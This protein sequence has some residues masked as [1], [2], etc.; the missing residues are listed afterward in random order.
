MLTPLTAP[1][2]NM[3]S[4][5][6]RSLYGLVALCWLVPSAQAKEKRTYPPTGIQVFLG[7]DDTSAPTQLQDGRAQDLQNVMLGLS[8]DLR[9]R[10]G[11]QTIGGDTLDIGGVGRPN[12]TG[13]YYTKF[14]N[15][16]ERI[17]AV[18]G[19]QVEYLDGSA[20]TTATGQNVGI[21]ASQND[22]FVWTT[23]LDEIIGSNDSNQPIRYDGTTVN[24]VSFS[25]LSSSNVPTQAKV[26]SFFKNFL[27]FGNTVEG[28]T[29]RPTRVRWSNVGTISTWSDN[30]FN[31]VDAL[32]GQE[33]NC[34]AQ[35]YDNLYLGFDHS[36]YRMSFVGGSGTFTFSKVS[37]EH[38]CAAKNSM[39]QVVLG[40]GQSI[41]VFL[42]SD[43]EIRFTDGVSVQSLSTLIRTTTSSL[44]G[45]RLAYAVSGSSQQD[46]VLCAS[47][48]TSSTNN[49]CLDFQVEIG[50]WTKH[51]NV[52]ANAM[53]NVIDASGD[54]QIYFGTHNAFVYEF[55][56]P[57]LVDDVGNASGTVDVVNGYATSTSSGLTVLYDNSQTMS[58]GA[59]VGAPIEF[60][61]GTGVGLTS[62]VVYNTA[63]GL[64]IEPTSTTADST[65]SYEVGAIDSY[66]TTKWFD[67]GRPAHIKQLGELY[68]WAD[69]D[70][71][72]TISVGFARD[73]NADTATRSVSLASGGTDVWGTGVWGT[74]TWSGGDTVFLQV[75]LD[76]EG[77]WQRYRFSEDDPGQSFHLYGYVPIYIELEEPW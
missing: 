19:G 58:T 68:V 59:L 28:G 6:R 65:T 55:D 4:A 25:G 27:V 41:L 15:G 50:E 18:N 33:L 60:V 46:Y 51:T 66:Y 40:N 74:A 53:A 16:T 30:D 5:F 10:G 35:L 1:S 70:V 32:S 64:V 76:A 3:R 36:L 23:A 73:F 42:D 48:G 13:L 63:T 11:N 77:R 12:V 69:S 44:R 9:Q 17:I 47:T 71:S 54:F 8:K 45:S 62:T 22:Q 14:S 34:M 61:G 72:S 49:L 43:K 52:N 38:G 75:K 7:L 37:D 29:S 21:S 39:R 20:W 24:A 2:R 26:V 57:L 67:F 31:D 56:E